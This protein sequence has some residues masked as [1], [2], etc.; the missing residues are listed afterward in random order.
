MNSVPNPPQQSSKAPAASSAWRRLPQ[1]VARGTYSLLLAVF[2]PLAW[3][4]RAFMS[5]EILRALQEQGT[6]LAYQQQHLLKIIGHNQKNDNALPSH[7]AVKHAIRIVHQ[8]HAGSAPGDAITNSM[9]LIQRLLQRLGCESEIFVKYRAPELA[10]RLRLMDELPQHPNYVLVVHHSMGFSGFERVAMTPAAKILIY[11]NITPAEFF[12]DDTSMQRDI[13]LGHEQLRRWQPFI[14][15]ALADSEFN[16]VELRRLGYDP[17]HSCALLFDIEEMLAEHVNTTAREEPFTVLFVGRIVPSKGQVDLVDAFAAFQ[18]AFGKPCRLVLIGRNDAG[19]NY[20]GEIRQRASQHGIGDRVHLTGPVTDLELHDWYRRADLYVSLSRH[21][22]FGVPLVEAMAH[23][24]PVLAWPAGAVPYTLDGAGVLLTDRSPQAVAAAMLRLAT[25]ATHRKAVIER[26]SRSLQRF[27]LEHQIPHLLAALRL[28]G[29]APSKTEE[30]HRLLTTNMCFTVTGHAAGTYS[31]AA[32]NRAMAFALQA[33]VPG[34]VRFLQVETNPV[35]DLSN[36]PAEQMTAIATLAAR[37]KMPTGPHVVISQHYPPYVPPDPGDLALALLPWE[38]AL[39]PEA[40]VETLDHGFN[41]LLAPSEFVAKAL[42]DSGVSIP[43]VRSGQPAELQRFFELGEKRLSEKRPQQ[44]PVVFLHVSSCFPRKGIDV[45]LAAY[46]Q[47]FTRA[48]PVKLVIKGFPNP[49]NDVADQLA[50]LRTAR[51]DLPDIVFINEDLDHGALLELYH[52]ADA[53][54][55]PTRGE[56]F[57]LPAAEAI[58]AG[59]P[60]IV[61]GYGGHLDFCTAEEARFVDYLFDRSRSH[62]ASPHSVWVEPD[63]DDLAM[64]MQE[65]VR[66]V[67]HG[68]NAVACR[69]ARARTALRRRLASSTWSERLAKIAADLLVAPPVRPFRLGWVSSWEVRCG[70]ASYSD[71]LLSE[72]LNQDKSLL[73]RVVIFA[74]HRP[75]ETRAA[76]RPRVHPC[77]DLCDNANELAAAI[78]AEDV[79]VLVIQHQPGLI[80]WPSLARLL[81]DRRL[82]NRHV[83]VTLHSVSALLELGG[84]AQQSVVEALKG[85]SRVLVHTVQDLNL[86]KRLGLLANVTLFPH[87]AASPSMPQPPRNLPE[88]ANPLIGCYGYFLPGKGISKLIDAVALLLQHWPNLRLR[89]VNAAYPREISAAEIAACRAQAATLGIEHAIEWMNDFLP[90]EE[91]ITLLSGCDLLVLPYDESQES[92]SGAVRVALASGT[93]VA[94]TPIRLFAELGDAVARVPP[95]PTAIFADGIKSL[96]NSPE[97]RTRVQLAAWAWC[98]EHNWSILARRLRGMLS[99]LH[100]AAP[101]RH[102]LSITSELAEFDHPRITPDGSPQADPSLQPLS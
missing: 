44:K 34:R 40:M 42:L 70:V 73:T 28:A 55:L 1:A 61:T 26:Q 15:A 35:V 66:A 81:K 94:T 51:A 22:G 67:R 92:A 9:F 98:N 38:E 41:A 11:H 31:L 6:L 33:Y 8:F 65:I 5:S 60:L 16:A 32:I 7:A 79:D 17:V 86:L 57:N 91:S 19:T 24:I 23:R 50:R 88:T 83:V 14:S 56:G 21:E 74:D 99:G 78:A 62:V 101:R 27:Q 72:M 102:P 82:C 100:A 20:A 47:A 77:W 29:A 93:P 64:A 89:L 71:F 18:K 25:D 10:D 49:H 76:L 68:D 36:V 87:G 63:T 97:M 3:R 43:V 12:P 69:S 30:A 48:D 2:R 4:I 75:S 59:I 84:D 37:P 54:V 52:Q 90:H 80:T 85:V 45:L 39:L 13:A 58:A 95:S 46:A 53:V 96:L